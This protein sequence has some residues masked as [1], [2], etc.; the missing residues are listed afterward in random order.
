MLGISQRFN[1]LTN[2]VGDQ[3]APGPALRTESLAQASSDGQLPHARHLTRGRP[4][5]AYC[6]FK[7]FNLKYDSPIINANIIYFL[8]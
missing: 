3:V 4:A 1:G 7:F 8:T 6:T 2:G 5:K